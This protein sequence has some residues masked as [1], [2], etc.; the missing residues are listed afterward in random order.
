MLI[1]QRSKMLIGAALNAKNVVPHGMKERN[2]REIINKVSRIFMNMKG[3][4]EIQI[5]IRGTFLND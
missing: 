4:K 2:H 5:E 3:F 1:G